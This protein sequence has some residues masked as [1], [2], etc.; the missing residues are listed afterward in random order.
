ML[1]DM[2]YIWIEKFS[3]RNYNVKTEKY[4]VHEKDLNTEYR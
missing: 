2:Y 4:V 3:N 1:L